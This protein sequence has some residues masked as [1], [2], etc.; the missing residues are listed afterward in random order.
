MFRLHARCNVFFFSGRSRS[1]YK[2]NKVYTIKIC[3]TMWHCDIKNVHNIKRWKFQSEQ[4]FFCSMIAVDR[5]R[6]ELF[7]PIYYMIYIAITG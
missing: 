7:S 2:W 5:R 4:I 3:R 6:C 1:V